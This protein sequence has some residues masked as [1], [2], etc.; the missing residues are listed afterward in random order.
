MLFR[1]VSQSRYNATKMFLFLL[2]WIGTGLFIVLY[3]LRDDIKA[4]FDWR[5]FLPDIWLILG[6]ILCWPIYLYYR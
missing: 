2:L 1:S 4:G 5:L 6:S 3:D